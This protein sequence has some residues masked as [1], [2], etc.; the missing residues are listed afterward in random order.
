[1]HPAE[2]DLR[3]LGPVH[4]ATLVVPALNNR[5]EEHIIV[6]RAFSCAEVNAQ[7]R[8][9]DSVCRLIDLDVYS[10]L[11]AG[12]RGRTYNKSR[13]SIAELV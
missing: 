10:C 2:S 7:P 4:L 8:S 9:V 13:P 11:R 3:P 1:M 5:G 12:L 6:D